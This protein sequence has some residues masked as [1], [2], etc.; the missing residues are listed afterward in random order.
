MIV[1][2][3]VNIEVIKFKIS[4]EEKVGSL[5]IGIDLGFENFEMEVKLRSSV[6]ESNFGVRFDELQIEFKEVNLKYDQYEQ[7]LMV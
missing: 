5:V 7:Y 1:I 4:L 6:L 3:D 2:I